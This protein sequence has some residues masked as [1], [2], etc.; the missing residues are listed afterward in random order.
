MGKNGAIQLPILSHSLLRNNSTFIENPTGWSPLSNTRRIPAELRYH[1]TM[2]IP[3][4]KLTPST[5]RA[6][7]EEFVTRDGTDHS[8][9]ERRVE[10]VMGQLTSGEVELHFDQRSATINIVNV[11]NGTSSSG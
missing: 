5:L 2:L 7:V 6:I 8:S 1:V 4:G 3:H 9:V 10:S 11:G